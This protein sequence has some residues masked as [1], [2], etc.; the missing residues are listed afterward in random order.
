MS[1]VYGKSSKF[2]IKHFCYEIFI[3]IT[4]IYTIVNVKQFTCVIYYCF[5]VR[6]KMIGEI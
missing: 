5:K 6:K 3:S 1:T 2:N 4:F